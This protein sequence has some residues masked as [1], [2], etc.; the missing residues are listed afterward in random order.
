MPRCRGKA[1]ASQRKVREQS[2]DKALDHSPDLDDMKQ[3]LA[4]RNISSG[5]T[6]R[7]LCSE[8]PSTS[9]PR[10]PNTNSTPDE[11]GL[12]VLS[13][14]DLPRGELNCF[15]P[16]VYSIKRNDLDQSFAANMATAKS[17]R[18][19]CLA[20]KLRNTFDHRRRRRR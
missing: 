10:N 6:L 8:S 1:E 20:V 16:S 13:T 3:A 18:G 19:S 15:P 2:N 5:S 17:R 14:T 9:A 7:A 4:S 12:E 11:D